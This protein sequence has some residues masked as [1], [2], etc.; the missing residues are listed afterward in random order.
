MALDDGCD[1]PVHDVDRG[2]ALLREGIEAL[3]GARTWSRSPEE[4]RAALA[5]ATRLGHA[6]EAVRLDLV[7]ASVAADDGAEPGRETRQWMQAELRVSAGRA[8]GDVENAAL[9]D[10]DTGTLR[11]M[12]AAL[13]AGQV[14]R[15]HVDVARA[16]LA[17]VPTRLLDRHRARVDALVTEHATWFTP[18]DLRTTTAHL[19][20]V[21]APHPEDR[22]DPFAEERR[23]AAIDR[24]TTGMTQLRAQLPGEAGLFFHAVLDQL[25]APGRGLDG[26]GGDAVPQPLPGIT[27]PRTPAQRTADAL[28]LMAGL[29]A[30]SPDAGTRGAEPPRLV[31]HASVD[32]LAWVPGS[33]ATPPGLATCE[34]GG[35]LS[36]A[37]LQRLA[38]DA[39]LQVVILDSAGAVVEMRDPGRLANRAMRRALAARDGGC[40]FP[41]CSAP[42]AWCDAHHVVFWSR[43][44]KTVLDNLV[45]LCARHHT[46]IHAGEWAVTMR[47]AVPWF[48]PPKH[49]D[50][51]QTPVRNTMHTAIAQA[52]ALAQQLWLDSDVGP[53]DG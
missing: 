23:M 46:E 40:A 37:L 12:G 44:G 1:A 21:L 47:D 48:V 50:L 25:S 3:A 51:D 42:A 8:R 5:E 11:Q 38:C 49:L 19:V 52:T 53:P 35:P 2:L 29:A 34:T 27:D 45:L 24:D 17:G 36:A 43:G 9:L 10:P 7:R 16:A 6:L 26:D 22:L 30:A 28:V 14:S 4:V 20:G 15:D 18:R 39:V 31:V 13:A 32:Q 33:P 41:G